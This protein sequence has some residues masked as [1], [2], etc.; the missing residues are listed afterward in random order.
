MAVRG[1]RAEAGRGKAG[2]ARPNVKEQAMTAA[3][4]LGA[5]AVLVALC[6]VGVAEEDKGAKKGSLDAAKLVGTWKYVSGAKGGEE[7]KKDVFKGASV[8]ISKKTITLKGKDTFVL[9]YKLDTKKSPA[10]I[11]MEITKGPFGEGAKTTGIVKVKG[12]ELIMCYDSTGKTTPK[13]FE[14]EKDSKVHLFVLKRA[15]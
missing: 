2:A 12:D 14:S 7:V 3:R 1:R 8:I 4:K 13:K 15:K 5:A 10:T 9:S 6:S 11:A